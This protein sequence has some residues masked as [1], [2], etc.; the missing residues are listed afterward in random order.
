MTSKGHDEFNHPTQGPAA[1]SAERNA[2][3]TTDTDQAWEKLMRTLQQENPSPAWSK[4]EQQHETELL[5]LAKQN[6]IIEEEANAKMNEHKKE[7]VQMLGDSVAPVMKKTA[8]TGRVRRWAVGVAAAVVVLGAVATP[9]G[10]N[11]LASLLGQFRMEKVTEVKESDLEQLFSSVFAQG[12]TEEAVNRYGEFKVETGT[13]NGEMSREDAEKRLGFAVLPA[14]VGAPKDKLYVNN[15]MKIQLKLNV[16]EINKTMKQLGAKKLFPQS[17]DGKTVKLEV[18]PSANYAI[19]DG[20]K[21][22]QIDQVKV[23]SLTMDSSVG[24]ED[25]IDTVLSFPMLPDQLKSGL[26][27]NAILNGQLPLMVPSSKNS[28]SEQL[29]IGGVS[30]LVIKDEFK[31]EATW[32]KDGVMTVASVY[33]NGGAVDKELET[34]FQSK[35]EEM[36]GA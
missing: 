30:V 20:D 5:Q 31:K 6:Q 8:R 29:N 12:V 25:A 35:L 36:I 7:I 28:S 3:Y 19:V 13:F 21:S 23:P 24:L 34:F 26:Q 33:A 4:L 10:N 1:A 32:V 15:D 16:D 2:D 14:S 11:A 9:A 27:K 18:G 22:V 17:I